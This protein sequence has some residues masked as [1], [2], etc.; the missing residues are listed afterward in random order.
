M[1]PRTPYA[2][3]PEQELEAIR[4]YQADSL[5]GEIAAKFDV[6]RPTIRAVLKRHGVTLRQPGRHSTESVEAIEREVVR[7][8]LEG[9]RFKDIGSRLHVSDVTVSEIL[10]RKGL[11]TRLKR[12]LNS[13]ARRKIKPEQELEIV[14]AYE[15]GATI[16][17]LA[18]TYS[19]TQ[20]P[21]RNVLVRHGVEMRKRGGAIKAFSRNPEFIEKVLALWHDGCSQVSIG[22]QL[23]CSQGVISKLL[24]AQGIRCHTGRERHWAWKGGRTTNPAGYVSVLLEA[25]HP[26]FRMTNGGYVLEHRL[27]MAEYLGRPL[28]DHETV[29][30]IDGDRTHNL[31]ENLQLRIGQHGSHICYRCAD[32]G[33]SRLQPVPIADAS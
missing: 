19:C 15:Q 12:G 5:T 17:A 3:T 18:Q 31:V 11:H 28:L 26:F 13:T 8:R 33:S 29:H 1:F 23:G 20:I 7:L 6:T 32:C 30:H 21:V 22:D 14:A 2:L 9:I 25:G 16:A 10:V 27:A 4:M 24:L